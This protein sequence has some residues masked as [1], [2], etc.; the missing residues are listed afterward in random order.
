MPGIGVA[1]MR[2][3]GIEAGDIVEVAHRSG[4][5]FLAFVTG[6]AAGGL[7]IKPFDRG[8]SYYSCRAREV[9]VH[10]SRRG[11]PRASEEPA[12]ASPLQ[13]ELDTTGR[14]ARAL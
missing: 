7:A 12:E 1:R 2:L 11:R 9:A 4:R 3:E 6:P 5:R 13:L 14:S 10:W 8:V